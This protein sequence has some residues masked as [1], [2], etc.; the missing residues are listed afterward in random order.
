MSDLDLIEVTEDSLVCKQHKDARGV[1]IIPKKQLAAAKRLLKVHGK[2]LVDCEGSK[3]TGIL[4]F[5]F[6]PHATEDE[7]DT[8]EHYDE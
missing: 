1:C 2:N 4:R 8:M 3:R 7:A 5:I 6:D